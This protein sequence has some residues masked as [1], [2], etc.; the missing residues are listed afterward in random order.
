MKKKSKK[1][2][3]TIIYIYEYIYI[4]Y[5]TIE[6]KY[7]INGNKFPMFETFKEIDEETI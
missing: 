3:N 2:L 6:T 7:N 5:S 1:E 4:Y